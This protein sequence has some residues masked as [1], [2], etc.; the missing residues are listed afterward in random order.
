MKFTAIVLSI[1]SLLLCNSC[2]KP[3]KNYDIFM[4]LTPVDKKQADLAADFL[5]K[6]KKD[7]LVPGNHYEIKGVCQELE[8]LASP[9][10]STQSTPE[11][12]ISYDIFK[13]VGESS[14]NNKCNG[15][16]E[17]VINSF[18][19]T[20]NDYLIQHKDQ[21]RDIIIFAQIPWKRTSIKDSAYN[22]LKEKM[23][24][25]ENKERIK[26]IYIFGVSET[27]TKIVDIFK[28]FGTDKVDTT[29]NS[30]SELENMINESRKFIK[31]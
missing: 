27:G 7:L 8:F 30:S 20:I 6:A 26:K 28:S 5:D 19:S 16:P 2:S 4:V 24:K 22:S 14:R 1:L 18:I 21:K 29:G 17:E 31:K 3:K 12:I 25:I 23:S 10:Y 11:S 15:S 9:D 13:W